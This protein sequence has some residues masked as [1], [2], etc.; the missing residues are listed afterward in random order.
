MVIN[1]FY[2]KI[3]IFYNFN[4][5]YYYD[6]YHYFSRML[7]LIFFRFNIFTTFVFINDYKYY[8]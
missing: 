2:K 6:N 8:F 5:D 4:Y 7:L 3:I 1:I